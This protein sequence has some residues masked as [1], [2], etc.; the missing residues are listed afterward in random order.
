MQTSAWHKFKHKSQVKLYLLKPL[1]KI[2][3]AFVDVTKK[4]KKV[5]F[6]IQN[7][8]S[9]LWITDIL[10][11]FLKRMT[12]N[13]CLL[14]V[15][16]LLF[17]FCI[18]KI[19][20]KKSVGVYTCTI[21]ITVYFFC[22]LKKCAALFLAI[23]IPSVWKHPSTYRCA[24]LWVRFQIAFR[25]AYQITRTIVWFRYLVSN[26]VSVVFIH[27]R[28]FVTDVYPIHVNNWSIVRTV[29]LN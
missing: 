14:L 26:S 7:V 21:G 4:K 2:K 10:I 8:G 13:K 5:Y 6:A 22:S 15:S 28:L 20:W 3:N 29:T 16:Y 23:I 1:K 17:F 25:V 19:C 12:R 24:F 18:S 27:A 11:E 9:V